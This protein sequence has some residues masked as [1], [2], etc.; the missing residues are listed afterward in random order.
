MRSMR[1]SQLACAEW[2]SMES[3][4]P[5]E[6]LESPRMPSQHLALAAPD[7]ASQ[8]EHHPLVL[9]KSGV[10]MG[11]IL[12]LQQQ[13]LIRL[14]QKLIAERKANS[15]LQRRL[16]QSEERIELREHRVEQLVAELQALKISQGARTRDGHSVLGLS[17]AKAAQK[18]SS[19]HPKLKNAANSTELSLD[20]I[21]AAVDAACA[22]C[23]PPNQIAGR[24]RALLQTSMKAMEREELHI[25]QQMESRAL[26]AEQHAAWYHASSETSSRHT[27]SVAHQD[28]FSQPCT[29]ARAS[30]ARSA[31]RSFP[32]APTWPTWCH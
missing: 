2:T 13:K 4:N 26:L 7:V 3:S 9:H 27:N 31:F 18:R 21:T 29:P 1:R 15:D 12:K 16:L 14:S 30:R 5:Y 20:G 6:Q 32:Q 11:S 19:H 10:G 24:L 17:Q 8:F 25:M 22:I 23:V 28:R